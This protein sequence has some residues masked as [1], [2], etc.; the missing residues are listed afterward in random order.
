[1]HVLIIT[2]GG[3]NLPFT[4]S[5]LKNRTFDEIIAAD[6]GVEYAMKLGI[7]PTRIM[8][9]FDSIDPEVAKQM[10]TL[11][12]PIETFPPEKDYTDTHLAMMR[13]MELGADEMTIIGATGTRLDHVMANIGLLHMAAEAGV[14]AYIVDANNKIT[15][16]KD[17]LTIRKE[18]AFGRYV[19]LIPYTEEVTGIDLTGFY[20]PLHDATLTIGISQGISNEITDD[21]ANVSLKTGYLLVIESRD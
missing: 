14:R 11:G 16:I 5:Y 18:D 12:A 17:T 3:M 1:M 2:G 8:G 9:D 7:T 13:A 10:K 15:M 6:K 21:V 20:Y 4:T 19:S